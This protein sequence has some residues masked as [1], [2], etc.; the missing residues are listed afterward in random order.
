M[1]EPEGWMRQAV[2]QLKAAFGGRLLFVG[3]QGSYRRG[4]ATEAS[5]IDILT[6]LDRVDTEDLALYRRVLR[7]LPEGEKACGFTCG[8]QELL[9]W[10]RHELFQF[11]QDTDAWHGELAPYLP[12]VSRGDIEAGL[13]VGAANLYHAAAHSYV[14]ADAGDRAAAPT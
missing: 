12:P 9:N 4:E 10:P 3:L 1:I 7:G 11:E 8:R 13:R 6:V 2:E 5:D 14:S